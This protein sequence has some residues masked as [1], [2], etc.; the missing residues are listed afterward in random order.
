MATLREIRT[1]IRTVRNIEKIT[2]A[3]KLVAAARLKRAQGRVEAARPYA[4]KME[5]MMRRLSSAGAGLTHP[6]LEVREERNIAVLIISSDRGLCGSY[7]TNLFRVAMQHLRGREPESV[8]LILLGRKG[9]QF[10]RRH[11]YLVVDSKA[12]GS[13]ADLSFGDIQPI[14]NTLRNLFESGE[15]DAVHVV[16]QRFVT[17][18]TQIPTVLPLLPL[19]PPEEEGAAA[20]TEAGAVDMIFEPEPAELLGRLLPRYVDT[21]V[22]RT[23]AEAIASEHGARMTS[24]SS[25]T[26]NAGEM[27]RNLTLSLNRAR[28]AQITKEIS[29]IVSGAEALK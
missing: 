19:K 29:E 26:E 15:V 13:G 10:F 8:K 25:A 17:A 21:Q 5:Q 9:Q 18:M 4:E 11:P 27:I 7:N 3:M 14:V 12:L 23:V 22:Y 2:R 24:M 16:Y 20:P 1:R 28:Q 6:L